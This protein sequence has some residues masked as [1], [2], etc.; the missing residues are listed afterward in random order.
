MNPARIIRK[1]IW[2]WQCWRM[3]KERERVM[4]IMREFD[5]RLAE[6]RKQ[7]KRGSARIVKAKRDALHSEMSRLFPT[8]A[9][10]QRVEESL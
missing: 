9:Q 7:H 10:R 4:P 3:R 2:G 5:R 1:A 6:Y 8:A